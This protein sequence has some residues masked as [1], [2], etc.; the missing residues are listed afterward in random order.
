M[1]MIP[2]AG[3]PHRCIVQKPL[4]ESLEEFKDRNPSHRYSEDLLKIDLKYTFLMLDYLHTVCH[5]IH[6][7]IQ[8]MVPT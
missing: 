4:W 7:G 5:V 2:R 1:F 6:T 3:G 8:D